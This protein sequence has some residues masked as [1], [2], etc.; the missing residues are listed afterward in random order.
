MAR[1][2]KLTGNTSIPKY[3]TVPEHSR[4]FTTGYELKPIN[5]TITARDNGLLSISCNDWAGG[6]N[7][8]PAEESK[9]TLSNMRPFIYHND[10][11][12]SGN[13]YLVLESGSVHTGWRGFLDH[14]PMAEVRIQTWDM[15]DLFV[16][17]SKYQL[18]WSKS[19]PSPIFTLDEQ[20][21]A[22]FRQ[23]LDYVGAPSLV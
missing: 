19:G 11:D 14:G 4:P 18:D 3:G 10:E 13:R 8:Y 16:T 2:F 6:I 15:F 1:Q 23:L 12:R 9:L 22:K 20:S 17:L 21:K 7:G 5:L